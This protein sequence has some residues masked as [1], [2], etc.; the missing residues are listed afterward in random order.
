VAL[1]GI[2]V[3]IEMIVA[4]SFENKLN[5]SLSYSRNRDRG[6][7]QPIE[8]LIEIHRAST[9]KSQI[10]YVPKFSLLQFFLAM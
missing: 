2:Y 9:E 6:F 8:I 5:Q 4:P 3:K 10:C 1:V 7:W